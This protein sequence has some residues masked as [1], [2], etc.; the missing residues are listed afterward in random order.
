VVSQAEQARQGILELAASPIM[1][2][3]GA[4]SEVRSLGADPRPALLQALRSDATGP[5][6][7][8]AS[9]THAAV[10]RDLPYWPQPA[11]CPLALDNAAAWINSARDTL[12]RC[13]AALNDALLDKARLLQAPALRQRLEQGQ[14]E[15]FIASILAAPTPQA[16]ADLLVEVL[17]SPAAAAAIE[18]LARYLKKI[19]V[20]KVRLADFHP[21]KHT[22]E[23]G[24]IYQVADEF[25]KFLLDAASGNSDENEIIILEIL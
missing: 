16:L 7:F 23:N 3:L 4:L 11:G 25:R 19:T 14:H 2:S 15:P 6:L 17:S 9:L 24:E 13:R 1:R 5:D 22:I 10:E 12:E 20:H 21:A 8:P 18:T